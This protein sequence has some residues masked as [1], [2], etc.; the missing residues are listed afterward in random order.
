MCPSRKA[1]SSVSDA[2]LVSLIGGGVT[3]ITALIS[4]LAYYIKVRLAQRHPTSVVSAD[5]DEREAEEK[6]AN[7][8]RA[9]IADI[10]E[11]RKQYREEVAGLREEAKGYR[12]EVAGL[13]RELTDFRD[14]DRKFR[15]ALA[16]WLLDIADAWNML[17]TM[18]YPRVGDRDLLEDVIPAAMSRPPDV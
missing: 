13:R 16:R 1:R 7:D 12:E 10:M 18:P 15:N 11:D 2:V 17:E 4:I 8:P 14:K 9:F 3:V 6:Y 5:D